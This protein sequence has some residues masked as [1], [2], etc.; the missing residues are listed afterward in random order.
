MQRKINAKYYENIPESK[1]REAVGQTLGRRKGLIARTRLD[2][3]QRK[4]QPCPGPWGETLGDLTQF[5]YS[6]PDLFYVLWSKPGC[7]GSPRQRAHAGHFPIANARKAA[8][9]QNCGSW[10]CPGNQGSGSP[11]FLTKHRLLLAWA[12][13]S[14]SY[15]GNSCFSQDAGQ[16]PLG[17]HWTPARVR[18]LPL[19][20]CPATRGQWGLSSP[21]LK[22]V[23]FKSLGHSEPCRKG[24]SSQ[25]EGGLLSFLT[26]R[27]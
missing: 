1:M 23:W 3:A 27:P 10:H 14:D 22:E 4:I 13:D 20:S 8:S 2:G 18:A 15:V 5:H 7:S 26:L 17:H 11:C 9:I 25:S 21:G 19:P 16:S 24:L 6:L 12:A